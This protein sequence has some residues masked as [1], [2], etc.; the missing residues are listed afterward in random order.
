VIFMTDTSG[1]PAA[2]TQAAPTDA[3]DA[4]SQAFIEE[5][6][7]EAAVAARKAQQAKARADAYEA[8]RAEQVAK[9]PAEPDN[10]PRD[11][12]GS[13]IV[14]P[15]DVTVVSGPR[16]V[17][18]VMTEEARLLA[19]KAMVREHLRNADPDMTGGL[20]EDAVAA[21]TPPPP[22]SPVINPIQPR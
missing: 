6:E 2:G 20:G 19:H 17:D 8:K 21:E 16:H 22:D 14:Q 15:G 11:A 10:R 12:F 7:D 13:P 4:Q 9:A 5:A 1:Y 18:M 3:V